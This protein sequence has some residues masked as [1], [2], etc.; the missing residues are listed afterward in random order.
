MSSPGPA[1]CGVLRL[2]PAPLGLV[3]SGALRC[4]MAAG[5]IPV[6]CRASL[7]LQSR[8]TVPTAEVTWWGPSWLCWTPHCAGRGGQDGM[9]PGVI[10]WWPMQAIGT[11]GDAGDMVTFTFRGVP[12]LRP[13]G[14]LLP[15]TQRCLISQWEG[16][17]IMLHSPI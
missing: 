4:P 6:L 7:W 3:P 16:R 15:I 1:E 11:R 8:G 13:W 12:Q 14:W 9:N 10:P 5:S 2:L 17:E